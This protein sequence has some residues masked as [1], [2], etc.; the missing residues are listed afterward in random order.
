MATNPNF[1]PGKQILENFPG[2]QQEKSDQAMS[3]DLNT[4]MSRDQGP[5]RWQKFDSS[6]Q[7]LYHAFEVI[8]KSPGSFPEFFRRRFPGKEGKLVLA[9]IG[10]SGYNLANDLSNWVN[11]SY[12]VC[13]ADRHIPIIGNEQLSPELDH[14]VIVGDATN[15]ATYKS[16]Q[17]KMGQHRANILIERFEGAWPFIVKDGAML[18]HLLRR[19]FRLTDEDSVTLLQLWFHRGMDIYEQEQQKIEAWVDSINNLGGGKVQAW[20]S[21]SGNL[22]IDRHPGSSAILPKFN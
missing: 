4:T 9:E 14:T 20:F 15:P 6:A 18:A 22:R 13:L 5:D 11:K 16:L 12:A 21:G 2:R 1:R 3:F 8:L 19:S 10:G 17:T 7:Q